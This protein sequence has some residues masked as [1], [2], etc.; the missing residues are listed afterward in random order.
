MSRKKSF[1]FKRREALYSKDGCIAIT[2][3]SNIPKLELYIDM[4]YADFI[5][6]NVE[7]EKRSDW[8]IANEPFYC[9]TKI[10]GYMGWDLS[11]CKVLVPKVTRPIVFEYEG[12]CLLVAPYCGYL[13]KGVMD[14]KE[15]E[16]VAVTSYDKKGEV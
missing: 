13:W 2:H 7:Q 5:K 8:W 16:E 15:N 6:W 1:V 12:M 4:L 14:W 11:D 9:L 3:L 10:M